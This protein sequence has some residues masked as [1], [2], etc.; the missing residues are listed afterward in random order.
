RRPPRASGRRVRAPPHGG[1]R[2]RRHPRLRVPNDAGG[3]RHV[4]P[5][6]HPD[7]GG[8]GEHGGVPG[9][10]CPA[11]RP[12]PR[13]VRAR[14]ACGLEDPRRGGETRLPPRDPRAGAVRGSGAP[15]AGVCGAARSVVPRAAAPPDRPARDGRRRA[16]RFP[17][18]DGCASPGA[19]ASVATPRPQRRAVARARPPALAGSLGRGSP[20]ATRPEVFDRVLRSRRMNGILAGQVVRAGRP[21]Q[22]A[23][24]PVFIAFLAYAFVIFMLVS[25]VLFP[26]RSTLVNYFITGNTLFGRA[27]GPFIYSNPNDLAA[28]TI[29]MLGPTLALWASAPRGSLVRWAGVAGAA[30][31][32]LVIVLTQSRGGFLA[33]ATIAFPSAVT[34]ARR[35]PRAAIGFAALLALGLYLAPAGFWKRMQG[36][37][38]GTSVATISQMDPEG[39]AGQRF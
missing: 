13:R 20:R 29:L 33:L 26:V 2:R 7:Q 6:R 32:I 5:R 36:L 4:P 3:R 30:P 27:I 34:L 12:C 31:L 9:G 25:Y 18:P 35:R 15:E 8:P 37:E 28:L 22:P 23:W 24:T 19:R 17:G 39:S 21:G 11:A 38:K 16:V 10:A 14:P 1:V